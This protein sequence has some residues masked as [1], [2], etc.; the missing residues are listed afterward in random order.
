[1]LLSKF[2]ELK[3]KKT[4]TLY[5]STISIGFHIY[6][7]VHFYSELWKAYFCFPIQKEFNG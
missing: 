6:R 2:V 5:K 7:Y 1:M 4:Q 3:K